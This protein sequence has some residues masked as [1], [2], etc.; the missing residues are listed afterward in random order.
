M[1]K[2]L[3]V[4][5]CALMRSAVGA[6]TNKAGRIVATHCMPLAARRRCCVQDRRSAQDKALYRI[7][8]YAQDRDM[9][10]D[11]PSRNHLLASL[12]PLPLLHASLEREALTPGRVLLVADAPMPF[13]Y[14]PVNSIVS[15]LRTGADGSVVEVAMVGNEGMLDIFAAFAGETAFCHGQSLSAGQAYRL[16][17]PVLRDA[18]KAQPLQQHPFF[19]YAR[20]LTLQLAQMALCN[21][22]HRLDQQLCRWLLQNM[23]RFGGSTLTVTQEVIAGALGVRREGVTEAAGRLQVAGVIHYSRGRIEVL[24]RAALER[25]AC[26]CYRVMRSDTATP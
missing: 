17:T 10:D 15:L 22:Q 6:L 12:L 2:P 18:L 1:L 8:G 9:M 13:V 21:R 23:D 5:A 25:Q 7:R 19:A 4:S 20:H 24:N 11:S 16:P 26:V 3:G 14:F